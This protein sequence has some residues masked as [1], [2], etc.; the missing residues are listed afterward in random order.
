MALASVGRCTQRC[1]LLSV[2]ERVRACVCSYAIRAREES[3]SGSVC[4]AALQAPRRVCFFSFGHCGRFS[5]GVDCLPV[6]WPP[7]LPDS[8]T[9]FGTAA[10]VPSFALKV[11]LVP[12]GR[13]LGDDQGALAGNLKPRSQGQHL[14]AYLIGEGGAVAGGGIGGGSWLRVSASPLG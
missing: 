14:G 7:P 5:G 10:P 11:N 6:R 2:C 3:G 12:A 1:G 13:G 4:R 9:P 8:P